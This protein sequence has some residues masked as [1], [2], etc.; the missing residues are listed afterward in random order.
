M[1]S[2]Y[3]GPK[4]YGQKT[5]SSTHGNQH[6]MLRISSTM[7]SCNQFDHNHNFTPGRT[8]YAMNSC[9]SLRMRHNSQMKPQLRIGKGGRSSN[10]MAWVCVATGRVAVN[11]L[12]SYIGQL[13]AD[14]E[15]ENIHRSPIIAC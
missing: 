1:T 5:T 8:T 3:L 6:L 14:M 4:T 10:P 12:Q 7:S 15:A 2:S 9:A 13:Q 11:T